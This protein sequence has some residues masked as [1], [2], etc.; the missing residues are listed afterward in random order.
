MNEGKTEGALKPHEQGI[1][2]GGGVEDPMYRYKGEYMAG[3]AMLFD[4][5]CCV[6]GDSIGFKNDHTWQPAGVKKRVC[7]VCKQRAVEI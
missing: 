4:A 3:L 6:Q 5:P 1:Q 2:Y 7:K